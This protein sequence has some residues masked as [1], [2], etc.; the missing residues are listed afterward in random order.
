LVGRLKG[1]ETRPLLKGEDLKGRI[2][3]LMDARLDIYEDTADII[4][5]TDGK[6]MYEIYEEL[7]KEWEYL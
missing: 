2:E 6:T 1:D 7:M 5:G 4:V 3:T